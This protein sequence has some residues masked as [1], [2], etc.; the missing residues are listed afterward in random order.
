VIVDGDGLYPDSV[1]KSRRVPRRALPA[2]KS[3]ETVAQGVT[4]TV[5]DHSKPKSFLSHARICYF[6]A[7]KSA[8][9]A[10]VN[11]DACFALF[12]DSGSKV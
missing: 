4:S 1:N 11:E 12:G 10:L 8:V 2:L 7:K 3:L 9:F 5:H 6:Q